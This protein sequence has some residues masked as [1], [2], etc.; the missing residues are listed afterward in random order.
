MTLVELMVGLGLGL[1]IVLAGTYLYLSASANA[2]L[3][4]AQARMTADAATLMGTIGTQLRMAGF[5]TARLRSASAAES[6]ASEGQFLRGCDGGFESIGS[7]GLPACSSGPAGADAIEIAYEADGY[8]ASGTGGFAADCTSLAVAPVAINEGMYLVNADSAAG[9][10]SVVRNRLY[11]VP[12]DGASQLRCAGN[13]GEQPFSSST[14]VANGV[15]DFQI[16]YS[17]AVQAPIPSLVDLSASEIAK[18]HASEE[19]AWRSVRAV[20]VCLV[21]SS[22]EGA[23]PAPAPHV[24]CD[25]KVVTVNDTRLR[26]KFEASFAVRN[27]LDAGL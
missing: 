25:G 19:D 14:A 22:A 24:G 20:R 2:R 5:S 12:V 10:R 27:Q 18:H 21:L 26:Q 16:V 1:L 4:R 11:L 8:N 9:L 23:L 6:R 15:H 7:P 13:G 17:V 3:S